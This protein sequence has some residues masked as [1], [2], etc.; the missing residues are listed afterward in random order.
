MVALWQG[1]KS[2]AAMGP[3][4]RGGD[5][6]GL[7]RRGRLGGDGGRARDGGGVAKERSEAAPGRR[8]R[9]GL[10]FLAG[11]EPDDL[12]ER[13]EVDQRGHQRHDADPAPDVVAGVRRDQVQG[14]GDQHQPDDDAEDAVDAANVLGHFGLSLPG[15]GRIDEY[16]K[17]CLFDRPYRALR[18]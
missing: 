7:G 1:P 6:G 8:L 11:A 17:L 15:R 5:G 2:T 12:I 18:P 3:R 9:R 10:G 14:I 13:A 16:Q 4:L